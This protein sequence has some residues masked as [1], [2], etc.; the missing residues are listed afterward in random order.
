M[1]GVFIGACVINDSCAIEK[2]ILIHLRN[3]TQLLITYW[4]H[5]WQWLYKY[6][7]MRQCL[8]AM[9]TVT[10]WGWNREDVWVKITAFVLNWSQAILVARNFNRKDFLSIPGKNWQQWKH[11]NDLLLP[12]KQTT[13]WEK[14]L[15][16]GERH[17]Y[18]HTYLC[19]TY[20]AAGSALLEKMALSQ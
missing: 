12:Q 2:W 8:A 7:I 11:T 9:A 6:S 19:W 17:T 16:H 1:E 4:A 20:T 14:A 18:T 10:T 15:S 13:I 3:C 5:H